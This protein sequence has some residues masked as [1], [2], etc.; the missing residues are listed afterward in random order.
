[1]V[2]PWSLTKE[3]TSS[4]N[5]FNYKSVNSVKSQVFETKLF[6]SILI[7]FCEMRQ[8]MACVVIL[9]P[10]GYW[11]SRSLSRGVSVWGV[12]LH[13]GA[14]LSGGISIQGGLLPGGSLSVGSLSKGVSVQGGPSPGWSLSIGSLYKGLCQ[15]GGL[16]PGGL[17][18][19]SL[20]R[21]SL[22]RGASVKR[23]GLSGM[24]I[25]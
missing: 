6:R 4:N 2:S 17:C 15:E 5:P 21:G 24:V 1:M 19:G 16:C 11:G 8:L 22:S 25:V 13:P 14:S 10:G 18:P 23:R 9:L 20:S 12:G 3:V 7:V